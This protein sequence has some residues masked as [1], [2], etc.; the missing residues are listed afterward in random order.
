MSLREPCE[1]N[2]IT[3]L[4]IG[5]FSTWG[6]LVRYIMDTQNKQVKWSWM[7]VICQ[8]VVSGFTGLTGGM[9]SVESGVSSYTTFIVAGLFGTMGSTA[10]SYLWQRIVPGRN[11]P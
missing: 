9:L 1:G 2:I 7:G 4:I 10:L 6:G 5:A 11:L 3:W 8:L